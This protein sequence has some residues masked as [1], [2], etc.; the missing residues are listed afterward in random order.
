ML[1]AV[2]AVAAVAVLAALAGACSPI[3]ILNAL[4]PADTYTVTEGLQFGPDPRHRLDVYRPPAPVDSPLTHTEYPV[5]VFFY[6]G[7]WVSG[8]RRDYK[9]IGEALASA[10]IVTII[11]DYRL[12]PQVRYP[13][14][15]EDGARAVAWAQREA[16]RYGGD[17]RRM[18]VMGHSSGA[19][20]AAMLALDP[21][22]LTAQGMSPTILKGWI[23][24]AGPYDFLPIENPAAKPVFF[25]PTI[26]RV[27]SLSTTPT[28]P[29][30]ARFLPRRLPTRQ[31]TQN[32]IPGKWRLSSQR[33]VYRSRSR[34]TPGWIT[35]RLRAPLAAHCAGWRRC[36]TRSSP[37]CAPGA[38]WNFD[39]GKTPRI[40]GEYG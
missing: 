40:S 33:R 14:F 13:D 6:G 36:A 9:F 19:Y 18:Y 2:I 10:G 31:S 5:V 22:W 30:P 25:I 26:R 37:L 15:L 38:D 20:N 32:A 29:R 21:R 35:L 8:E 12:Y 7:T 23:G 11:A 39:K 17:P 1:R 27:R 16:G 34:Y 28:W 4:T 24:L 3:G